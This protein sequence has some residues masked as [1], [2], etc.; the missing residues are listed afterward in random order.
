MS[1]KNQTSIF[2]FFKKSGAPSCNL[3]SYEPLLSS[4]A[5]PRPSAKRKAHGDP[6]TA[7]E[8]ENV[9]R[10][11]AY[12]PSWVNTYPWL[13]YDKEKDLMYCD[14]CREYQNTILKGKHSKFIQGTDLFRL[15]P[16]VYHDSTE[17]HKQ[18]VSAQKAKERPDDTPLARLKQKL[19][20]QLRAR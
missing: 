14:V 16:V 10:S 3:V 4:P 19:D 5:Q 11:R 8:Y 1:T 20:E 2:G 13:R 12:Q 6:S 18:C 9:K 17:H 7:R 15:D